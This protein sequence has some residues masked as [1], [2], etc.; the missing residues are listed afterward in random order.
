MK[1]F[2]IGQ[3]VRFL[4]TGQLGVIEQTYNE[5]KVGLFRS[6]SQAFTVLAH[7]YDRPEEPAD[8][9]DQL[10]EMHFDNCEPQTIFRGS[11]P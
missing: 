7:E 8:Q 5:G 2:T 1:T 3:E 11:K 4:A 9:L 10:F 6:G